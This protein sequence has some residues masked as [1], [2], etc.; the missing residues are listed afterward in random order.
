MPRKKKPFSR[1]ASHTTAPRRNVVLAEAPEPENGLTAGYRSSWAVVIGINAYRHMEKLAFAVNDADAMA[2]FLIS[3]LGFPA[4]KVFAILDP[5]PPGKNVPYRLAAAQGVKAEIERLIYTDMP[6]LA[7]SDDRVIIFF[8]GHGER[9]RL[10]SGEEV[11]YLI[12]ADA[13]PRQWHTYI[14]THNITEAGN[15]CRAKHVF[16]LFDAC[17]SGLAFTRASATPTPYEDTMLKTR[18]RQALTAGT[19]KEAVSDK[20]PHGHSPF[21]WYVL[22]GLR[23]EAAQ[24]GSQV[25]TASDLMVYVKNEV[26]R[27]FGARQTPDFGKLPGHESGGDFIFRMPAA[28]AELDLSQ[29]VTIRDVGVEPTIAAAAVVTAAETLMQKRGTPVR[30]AIKKLYDRAKR[31]DELSGEGTW[32]TAVVYVAEQFGIAVEGAG[33]PLAGAAQPRPRKNR[34]PATQFVYPRFFRIRSLQEIPLQLALGRP[35]V[36]GCKVYDYWLE[37][38]S[39]EIAAPGRQERPIGTMALTIVGFDPGRGSIRFANAWSVSWGQNGFGTMGPAA[40]RALLVPDM[41]WALDLPE[42]PFDSGDMEPLAE[43][44]EAE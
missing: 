24:K 31:H 1:P 29:W 17:Y 14:P 2:R 32:L 11:G 27:N 15:Y 35:V 22:Q 9:R 6:G 44:E 37:A 41:M 21:T 34:P 33:E 7:E 36:A 18:A 4:D 16:Y 38:P 19:A 42:A 5:A 40:M 8:A 12:P 39:G 26:G 28:S 25:V 20:G 13:K 23:G 30:L 10:P 3:E 43:A